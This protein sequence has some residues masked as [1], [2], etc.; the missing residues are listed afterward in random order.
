[1]SGS[2]SFDAFEQAMQGLSHRLSSRGMMREAVIARLFQHTGARLNDYMD[3]PFKPHGLNATLWT[4]LVVI[5]ASKERRLKPS[6]LSVYMNSSRMN[7]TRVAR[8]LERHGLT[9]R[10]AD[11][12][13]GRQLFLELTRQGIAFVE[14]QLPQRRQHLKKA[15]EGF[16]PD[17]VDQLQHL[18]RKLLDNLE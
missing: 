15:F 18:L 17:E 9:R 8:Q 11:Q 2:S 10:V 7:S 16:T 6:E 1:M 13:D 4:S 12:T 3:A 5:Y 14:S